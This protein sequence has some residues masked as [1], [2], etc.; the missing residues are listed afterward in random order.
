MDFDLTQSIHILERTPVVL[1][2]LLK[3]LPSA[4]TSSNEGG[5]SWSPYDVVGHLV[6]GEKTDWISRTEI[7]LSEGSDKTFT[8]FDRFAQFQDSQGKSMEMLLEEFKQLRAAN[9]KKIKAMQLT[10]EDY[11][12]TGTHPALGKATLGQLLAT[13][14]VHDMGHI[15]QITRVMAKQYKNAVGPWKA[16]LTILNS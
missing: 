2:A 3:D 9:M 14:T 6:H 15:R 8:P 13:W 7:I 4:W 1:E 5:D 12:R 11:E 10:P 16:Y